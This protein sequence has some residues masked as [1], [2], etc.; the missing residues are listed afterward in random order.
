MLYERLESIDDATVPT[1]E[2]ALMYAEAARGSILFDEDERQEYDKIFE[3][4]L[5]G[6]I[7]PTAMLRDSVSN[8]IHTYGD[9]IEQAPENDVDDVVLEPDSDPSASDA[10][11][12]SAFVD[13][14]ILSVFLVFISQ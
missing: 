1:E 6:S 13:C 5:T 4:M 14:N 7:K 12:T 3:A 2:E 10:Y 11:Q 9:D 8:A